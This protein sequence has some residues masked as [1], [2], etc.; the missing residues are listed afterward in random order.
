MEIL[1]ILWTFFPIMLRKIIE[2]D[3]TKC[4]GC[5]DC[6]P[7]CP[8]GALQ[9]IDGKARMVSEFKCDGL[10]ACLRHCPQNAMTII[11]KEAAPYD[12][13]E[14]IA[15]I[16]SAGPATLRAHLQ[17][18]RDHGQTAFLRQAEDFLKEDRITA[19][20]PSLPPQPQPA[21][22]AKRPQ[23][24]SLPQAVLNTAPQPYP[25]PGGCPGSRSMQ[26]DPRP[27]PP[28]AAR[29]PASALTHWPIQLHLAHPLATHFQKADVLLAADCTAFAVGDFHMTHL[30]GKAL[31]IA[32][33]KLD[34]RQEVYLAKLKALIDQAEINTLTVM[35]ME[36][37][38]CG[39][40]LQLAREARCQAS[41]PVPMN[42]VLV[43][44][45]GEILRA[46]GVED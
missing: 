30:R 29:S 21:I 41:R 19:E 32:C 2:I 27:T 45:R 36:V 35:I 17:H 5:G 13:R 23:F 8:E 43:S 1:P 44:L 4:N 31:V 42:L 38:C 24:K 33:P 25:S 22:G 18:L 6:L 26:F 9:I 46:Q 3:E 20:I 14:V 11:E 34:E 37:P 15:K 28:V 12:E 16:V 39:G 10:G 7:N 40:L